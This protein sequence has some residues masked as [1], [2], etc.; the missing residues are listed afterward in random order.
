VVSISS[1]QCCSSEEGFGNISL[2][3]GEGDREVSRNVSMVKWGKYRMQNL[4]SL[5]D[6]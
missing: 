3:R 1:D 2:E 5:R 6:K 4:Q